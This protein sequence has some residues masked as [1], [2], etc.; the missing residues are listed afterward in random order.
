MY[1][2]LIRHGIAVDLESIAAADLDLSAQSEIDRDAL[3]SLT[4]VGRKKIAQVAD[5]LSELDV[6]FDLIVSSPLIRAHQTAEILMEKQLSMQ[7]EIAEELK[8]QGNLPAWLTWWQDRTTD[9]SI[10]TLALVGHEPNLSHWAE[11]LMFGK[12]VNRIVLKKGGIIGL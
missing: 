4:K 1:L 12:V 2:Y 7:V 11:L 3:R 10:S 5:R 6:T 8:P 9:R